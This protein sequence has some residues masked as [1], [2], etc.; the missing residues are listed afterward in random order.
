MPCYSPTDAER[1]AANARTEE[2]SN[3]REVVEGLIGKLKTMK[4]ELDDTT[5]LLCTATEAMGRDRMESGG[6][7]DLIQWYDDH[8]TCMELVESGEILDEVEKLIGSLE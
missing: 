7:I 4:T 2:R 3:N 5:K 8:N 1:S 6:H